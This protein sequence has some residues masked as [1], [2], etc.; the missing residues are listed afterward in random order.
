MTFL[1][2]HPIVLIIAAIVAAIAGLVVGFMYLWNNCEGFR[3][4]FIGMWDAI[5]NTVST[6]V[7]W[8]KTTFTQTL[9]NLFAVLIS[10]IDGVFKTDWTNSFGAFGEILNA[11]FQNLSNIWERIKAIFQAQIDFIK[12]VFSGN[13]SAAWQNIVDIF[14]N[15]FGLIID[16]AKIPINGI[17]G[18]L[19]SAVYGIN[20]LIGGLN[21]IKFDIPSWVP[22]LG[23]KNFSLNIPQI[24]HIPLLA[25]GGVLSEGQAI[26]AEAG[27][28]LVQMVGGKATVTPLSSSS[29]NTAVGGT[30][31]LS[32]NLDGNKIGEIVTPFVKNSLSNQ[33]QI[34]MRSKGLV[35]L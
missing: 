22:M 33:L 13:W 8:F 35:S 14:K 31:F 25:K 3:N 5:K 19:N 20:Q 1:L 10:W 18:L 21:S 27:P 17:I 26:I 30:M 24:P 2:A 28:E 16:Y 9:P 29:Q 11:F 15:V 7:D 23:G 12:N 32:L 4:F 6:V 34:D